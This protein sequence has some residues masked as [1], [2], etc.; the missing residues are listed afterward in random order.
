MRHV[1][2]RVRPENARKTLDMRRLD[3]EVLL[4]PDYTLLL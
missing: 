4:L 2:G 3:S 1:N